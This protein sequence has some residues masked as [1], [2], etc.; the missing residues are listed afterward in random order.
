MFERVGVHAVFVG[1]YVDDVRPLAE[2]HTQRAGVTELL[3]Q[4]RVAFVN[5]GVEYASD[6]AAGAGAQKDV[7]NRNVHA[8]VVS[9]RGRYVLT[10]SDVALGRRILG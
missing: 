10:E 6:G 2:K 9:Q 4:N 1:R 7:V 3:D 5:E 8:S